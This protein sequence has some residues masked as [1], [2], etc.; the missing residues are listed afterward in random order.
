MWHRFAVH[1]TRFY[2]GWSATELWKKNLKNITKSLSGNKWVA[3]NIRK[4]KYVTVYRFPGSTENPLLWRELRRAQKSP[5]SAKSNL[6]HTLQ[7]KRRESN[8][9]L[10]LSQR[11]SNSHARFCARHSQQLRRTEKRTNCNLQDQFPRD[12]QENLRRKLLRK[13]TE[14]EK[15]IL[16]LNKKRKVRSKV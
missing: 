5:H 3:M 4:S 13:M 6:F 9:L 14:W 12:F 7:R 10:R 2:R 1:W 15:K 11:R 8:S 16:N